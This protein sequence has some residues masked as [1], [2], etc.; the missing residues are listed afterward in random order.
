MSKRFNSGVD[1]EWSLTMQ[2]MVP[3][4]KPPQSISRLADSRIGGQHL[5]WV[6][7]SGI[8]SEVKLR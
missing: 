7:P 6:A 5:N 4:R 1:G 3:S 2:S 8:D